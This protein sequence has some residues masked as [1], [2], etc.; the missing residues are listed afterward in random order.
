MWAHKAPAT[1]SQNASNQPPA[2]VD[3]TKPTA[4]TKTT[5]HPSKVFLE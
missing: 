2:K 5:D 1:N 4:T 3:A